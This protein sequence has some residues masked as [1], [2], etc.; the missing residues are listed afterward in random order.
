MI[1]EFRLGEVYNFKWC[2][3]KAN[4]LVY[5]Y[6]DSLTDYDCVADI[7]ALIDVTVYVDEKGALHVSGN[8]LIWEFSENKTLVT[9][10][11]DEPAEKYIKHSKGSN[12][13]GIK[14]YDYV[15]GW[16]PLKDT[17]PIKYILNFYII[18]IKK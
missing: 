12:W 15:Q 6:D 11:T 2:V 14:P 5:F 17:M 3:I 8:E 7:A 10:L 4:N 13:L 16:Y 9:N 1:T 18:G